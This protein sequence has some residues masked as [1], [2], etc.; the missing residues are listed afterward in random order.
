MTQDTFFPTKPTSLGFPKWSY[1]ADYKV[2][3]RDN[4]RQALR[5][6]IEAEVVAWDSEYND[7]ANGQDVSAFSFSTKHGTGWLLPIGMYFM[8]NLPLSIVERFIRAISKKRNVAMAARHEMLSVMSTWP[9]KAQKLHNVTDDIQIIWYLLDPNEAKDF[10]EPA[11]RQRG[12]A[13]P[14]GFSQHAMALKYL[15]L[16]TPDLS[17]YFKS[18]GTFAELDPQIARVYACAD[19]DVCLRLFNKGMTPALRD[20]FIYRLEMALLPVLLDMEER[21]FMFD[22]EQMDPIEKRVGEHVAKLRE[23]AYEALHMDPSVNVDSPTQLARHVANT[24]NWPL[25]TGKRRKDN[26]PSVDKNQMARWA[27]HADPS[28]AKGA[29][30]YMEY[31]K[32]FTLYNNFVTKLGGYVNPSTGAIHCSLINTV[33]PTGRLACASPNLQQVPKSKDAPVRRAFVARPGYFLLSADYSQI[34]LRVY[35]G[36]SREQY[37]LESFETGEDHHLKTASR[38][39]REVITDKDDPRRQVGK[40]MNF[41]PIYGMTSAGLAMRTDYNE[42]EAQA[43]LDD[44]FGNIPDAV[45]WSEMVINR[46]KQKG[47]VHTHFGRWRPLPWLFSRNPRDVAFG[48]RSSVNTEVQGTAADI[49]KIGLIRLW[50]ALKRRPDLDVHLIL[51]VH[52]SA[53]MEIRIGTDLDELVP[54]IEEAMCIEI[55][56]Y[57]PITIDIEIGTNWLEMKALKKGSEKPIPT[58]S[59]AIEKQ[60]NLPLM[61]DEQTT[62][63]LA[64]LQGANGNGMIELVLLRPDGKELPRLRTSEDHYRRVLRT[65]IQIAKEP[66][67]KQEGGEYVPAVAFV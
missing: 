9:E 5:E 21:G 24:L 3:T 60:L 66:R 65:L 31:K 38:I 4:M 25:M 22:Q 29:T 13:V 6:I 19:A 62:R 16:E 28:I 67:P 48:E 23:Q 63:L 55:E 26:L 2:V 50:K 52:D 56:G 33:V 15:K 58:P 40:T 59:T 7:T 47:G 10:K 45:K 37:F 54:L 53:L 12:Q 64:V 30:A 36:E 35:A 61:T 57:P 11:P 51:T 18:G 1:S 42:V 41:G 34:E 32:W 44:F 49:L 43:I 46:A 17:S 27:E 8:E 14:Q 39:F 20:S